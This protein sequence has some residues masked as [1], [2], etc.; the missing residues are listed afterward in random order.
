RGRASIM[1]RT[2]RSPSPDPPPAAPPGHLT[3][4]ESTRHA[5]HRPRVL[6]PGQSRTNDPLA[7]TCPTRRCCRGGDEM[8]FAPIALVT[9][10]VLLVG[11]GIFAVL[12][13][14]YSERIEQERPDAHAHR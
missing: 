2:A 11:G 14:V 3:Q 8:D 13:G 10:G 7:R 4:H 6:R 1:S 12:L 5:A 9:S